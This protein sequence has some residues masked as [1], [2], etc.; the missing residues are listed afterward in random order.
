VRRNHITFWH[1]I[2][3][4]MMRYSEKRRRVPSRKFV[5]R[6]Y[7]EKERCEKYT[8]VTAQFIFSKNIQ[9]ALRSS[10]LSF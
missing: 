7:L 1:Y 6:Y 5:H 8:Y 2:V 9:Y 3:G 4:D 10:Y